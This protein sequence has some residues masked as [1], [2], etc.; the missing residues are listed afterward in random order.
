MNGNKK[1]L[2]GCAIFPL[3]VILFFY[4][5]YT[6]ISGGAG[7]SKTKYRQGT[8]LALSPS[9]TIMDYN[10]IQRDGFFNVRQTSVQEISQSIRLAASDSKIAGIIIRPRF[11]DISYAGLNEISTAIQ[12]FKLSGKQVIA[13]LDMA[14]QKDYLLCMQADKVYMESSASAGIL[15]EGVNANILFY[16]EMLDKL[17]IRF[18]V[19]QSGEVKG[20]GEPYTRTSL[21]QNIRD[22]ISAVLRERYDLLISGIARARKQE[23]VKI[24]S[25]FEDRPDP[26]ITRW[27]AVEYGLVDEVL[28]R[29]LML[30]RY[31][32]NDARLLNISNYQRF[33]IPVKQIENVAVLNLQG[34]INPAGGGFLE[35]TINASKVQKMI[36]QVKADKSIKAVVLRIN[37]PGGSALESELIYHKLMQLKSRVPI[38]VSMAGVAASGGYYIS[39]PAHKIMAD[40]YTITGSIGVLMIIPEAEGLGRKIG[41]R[42]QN[43]GFGKYSGVMDILSRR[44]PEIL[45]S[46]QRSADS[47]YVEFKSRVARG[48]SITVEEVESLAKG[49]VWSA[50]TALE[51]GLID[52][53]GNMN[54]AVALAAELANIPEYGTLILPTPIPF[55]HLFRNQRL[56]PL[57]AS[58]FGNQTLEA[59]DAVEAYIRQRF[60]ANE[61]LYAL[62]YDIEQ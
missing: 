31:D 14:C 7:I 12:E 16:K 23:Q 54:D 13:Y 51:K 52:G 22:N 18:D 9:G 43:I 6:M 49:Q 53:I 62:P 3:L 45:R 24:R 8:W 19:V 46:M 59:M 1:F 34:S 61:W 5:G 50:E 57:I 33:S 27:Q 2:L 37:S 39:A 60:S 4:I 15:L 10:E 20:G 48:R 55:W 32:I 30:A 17:G 35:N 42:S 40:P 29:D 25:V 36:D 11:A 26:F 44:S 58:F 41:L 28:N 56:L 21:P 38:V 47:I